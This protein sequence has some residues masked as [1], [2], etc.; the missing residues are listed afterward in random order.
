MNSRNPVPKE[1]KEYG[2]RVAPRGSALLYFALQEVHAVMRHSKEASSE[3]MMLLHDSEKQSFAP[4]V[5]PHFIG[6]VPLSQAFADSYFFQCLTLPLL[7]HSTLQ[8]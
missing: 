2:G 7:F 6:A 4:A 1:T 3:R 5:P 8:S